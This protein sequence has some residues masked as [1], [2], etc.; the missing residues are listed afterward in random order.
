MASSPECLER[1]CAFTPFSRFSNRNRCFAGGLGW[2]MLGGVNRGLVVSNGAETTHQL[3]GASGRVICGEEL[4]QGSIMCPCETSHGQ[5]FGSGLCEPSRGYSLPSSIQP[6]S[7]SLEMSP[8]SQYSS[9]CRTPFEQT[10][11]HGRLAVQV[12]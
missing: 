11:R 6:V 7:S 1:S 9:E 12:L 8:E 5:H 3:S 2:G 4:H 10:E